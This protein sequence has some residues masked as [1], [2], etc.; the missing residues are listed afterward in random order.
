MGYSK[1]MKERDKVGSK[2]KKRKDELKWLRW[3]YEWN[4]LRGKRQGC[5]I[6]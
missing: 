6:R 4:G 1:K 3:E 5:Q 2:N